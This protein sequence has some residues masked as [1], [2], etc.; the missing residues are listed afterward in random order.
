MGERGI[1]SLPMVSIL[2]VTNAA[3]VCLVHLPVYVLY[4]LYSIF[5]VHPNC[6]VL[7][8]TYV[9]YKTL[10]VHQTVYTNLYSKCFS[11]F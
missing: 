1:L 11:L 2:P 3:G 8:D 5:T 9:I 4:I 6:T 7:H 10:N